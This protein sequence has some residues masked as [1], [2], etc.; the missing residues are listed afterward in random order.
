[1]GPEQTRL[2]DRLL[3]DPTRKLLNFKFSPGDKS[4]KPEE[5]CTELNKALD[6]VENG[7]APSGPAVSGK[8][9]VNVRE[10]VAGIEGNRVLMYGPG[11]V[12]VAAADFPFQLASGDTVSFTME[13][14][15]GLV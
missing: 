14:D 10:L 1:M 5:V 8:P 4:S 9:R 3:N 7:L 12:T 13:F 2:M 11:Y 6:E 15:L